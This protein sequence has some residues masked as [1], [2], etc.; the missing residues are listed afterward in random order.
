MTG[1]SC[2]VDGPPAAEAAGGIRVVAATAA[3]ARPGGDRKSVVE[4]KGGG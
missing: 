2:A 4:G 3:V 1:G